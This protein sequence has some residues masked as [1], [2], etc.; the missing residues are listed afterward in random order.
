MTTYSMLQTAP[1]ATLDTLIKLAEAD[2]ALPDPARRDM[3]SGIRTVAKILRLEPH[4][5]PA[6][7]AE[8]RPLLNNALPTAVQISEARWRNAKSLLRKALAM[9]DPDSIPARS[10]ADLLPAWADL[11]AQ[12]EAAPLRRGLA[13]FSKYCSARGI[14]PGDVT[15]AVYW[16]APLEVLHP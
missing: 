11:L 9:L 8:L 10:R 6:S 2:P 5:I 16:S 4:L 14:A 13:R 3:I 1:K 7:A 12:P 15:Q